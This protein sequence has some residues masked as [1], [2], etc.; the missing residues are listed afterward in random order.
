MTRDAGLR[1]FSYD[2]E[3]VLRKAVNSAGALVADYDYYG[4]GTRSFKRAVWGGATTESRFFYSGDQ[5]VLETDSSAGLDLAGNT[6]L[7]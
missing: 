4:D 6:V 1:V 5:E 2:A 3:N 7:R